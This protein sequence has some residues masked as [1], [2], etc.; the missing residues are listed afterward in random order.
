MKMVF[1]EGLY[2][3]IGVTIIIT[4]CQTVIPCPNIASIQ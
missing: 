1:L 3:L 4:L 2:G